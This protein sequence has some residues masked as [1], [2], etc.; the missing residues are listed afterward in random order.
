MLVTGGAGFIGSN[1]V[2]RAAEGRYPQLADA[3]IVG[4]TMKPDGSVDLVFQAGSA[5]IDVTVEPGAIAGEDCKSGFGQGACVEVHGALPPSLAAGGAQGLLDD[6][7]L[8]Q[9]PTTDV[10]KR[11]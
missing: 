8:L 9:L 2:R 10:I 4:A 7:T 5:R 6:I 3:E 1:F 11:S